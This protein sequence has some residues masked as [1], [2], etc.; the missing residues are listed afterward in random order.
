[1]KRRLL[2]IAIFLLAGAL[3]NVAVAWGILWRKDWSTVFPAQWQEGEE[4]PWPREVPA[5]W[6]DMAH[7]HLRAK[8]FG[9]RA[10]VYLAERPPN[11]LLTF[12]GQMRK[13]RERRTEER[14]RR[15]NKD[16]EH[17]SVDVCR[18]GWP[19][20]GLGW[21]SWQEWLKHGRKGEPPRSRPRSAV[22]TKGHPPRSNW[23]VWGIPVQMSTST[24]LIR[25]HL[26]IRPS[27]PGFAVNTAFYAA[28]LWL[29]IPGPFA[30]RRS[31]RRRRDLCPACAYP[32]G[33]AAVCTECGKPLPEH[34]WPPTSTATAPPT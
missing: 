24:G 9:V 10:Q 32:M 21:E 7:A 33:N 3:V 20:L 2:I 5:H 13:E 34:S 6:P 4:W 22:R 11:S 18:A 8:G 19:M 1:M 28:I 17:F 14:R 31:I 23:W 16:R 27:W 15:Y 26:P 29:L 12:A 25:N 30:L